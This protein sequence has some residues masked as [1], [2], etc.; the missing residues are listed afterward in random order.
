MHLPLHEFDPNPIA[1]I[2]PAHDRRSVVLPRVGVLCWFGDVVRERMVEQEVVYNIQFEHGPH[3]VVVIEH[4]GVEVA[5]ACPGVGA[6]IAAGSLEMFIAHGCTTVV[7][8]GGAGVIRPGFDVGHVVIPIAAIRDEGTSYHYASHDDDVAPHQDVVAALHA[9][10]TAQGVPFEEAMTWTTDAFYRET[11]A[12]VRR[13]RE[14]GC[15]TVEMEASALFAVAAFRGARYGQ[16]LYCGDDLSA[17]SWDH[18]DWHRQTSVR[19]HLLDIALGAAIR[20]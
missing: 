6:P 3:P 8:V 5:L 1:V 12:K 9:E 13:R 10:L 4:N 17:G 20:L 14:Q 2:N 18:R 7:G 15:L 11:E 16:V 19:E